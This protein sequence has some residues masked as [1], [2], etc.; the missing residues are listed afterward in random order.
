VKKGYNI[1]DK[2]IYNIDEIEW[3][4]G[5]LNRRIVFIFPDI[6][7]VYMV[8]LETRESITSIEYISATSSYIPGFLILPS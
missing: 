6:S 4:V 5:C 3:R 1:K 8:S 2:N 7:A